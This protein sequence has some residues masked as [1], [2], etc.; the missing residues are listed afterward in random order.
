MSRHRLEDWASQLQ[1]AP[2]TVK[3]VYGFFNNDY[4]GYSIATCNR[5]KRCL[6]LPVREPAPAGAWGV[7]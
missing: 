2:K 4:A 5:M 6:G 1:S 7:V 3:T